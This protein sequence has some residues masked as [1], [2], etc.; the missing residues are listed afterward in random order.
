ML[1]GSNLI[2][3]IKR[4]KNLKGREAE[5]VLPSNA[6]SSAG[7]KLICLLLVERLNYVYPFG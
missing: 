3:S 4:I 2:L 5:I 7:G 1:T 6:M